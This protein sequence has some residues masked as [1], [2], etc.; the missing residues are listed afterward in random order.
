MIRFISYKNALYLIWFTG[1]LLAQQLPEGKWHHNRE[2]TID[3]VHYKAE[4]NL[5]MAASR[6]SGEAT[7]RFHPR[8]A[9][10]AFSL[11]AFNLN[12]TQVQL[13]QGDSRS[14]LDFFSH[15]RSLAILLDRAYTPQ[16]TLSVTVRYDCQPVD[17]M[18]FQPD[19]ERPGEMFVHTYGEGGLHANWLPI[20]ND[21]N[22]KFSTEM[23]VT[24]PAGYAAIS[25]GALLE[26]RSAVNGALTYH[27]SQ[28]LPHANY[29]I[30]IYA[31]HFEKGELPPAFGKIPLNYWVPE[32]HLAEGAFA[33]RNTTRMVEFFSRQFNH[34]Y[35]WEKYDQVAVPDYAIGAMEHTG[36]TGHRWS[37]LRD[38]TAPDNFGPPLFRQYHDFWTADGTISHELAHHW[39]GN[40]LTC[41]NL[42]YIWLNES[43]ASYLQ[44]LWDEEDLGRETLLLDRQVALD[45][46]LDYVH[47][48]HLIRPLEYH[49]FDMPDDIYN[50]AHTYLKGAI[51]LHMLRG[52]MG[53]EP[54]FR[55]MGYYLKKHQFANVESGDLLDA[56]AE[57]SGQ[58]LDWFFND[59]VYGGGHPV[60][61]VS[62]TYLPDRRQIDLQVK[63]VQA[64]VEGQDLFKLP[65]TVTVATADGEK[66]HHIWLE[67][68]NEAF[69]LP[70]P[71]EPLLVSFDGGGDLVAEVRFE[72]TADELAYQALNDSLPG[73]IQALRQ[74]AA[75][76]PVEAATMETFN[77][78]LNGKYFWGLQAEA[79]VQLG[80]V[81]TPAAAQ[82][83]LRALKSGD[84]RLRKAAA[85]AL[86]ALGAETAAKPLREAIEKDPHT[87]V[88]ATAIVALAQCAPD[89]AGTIIPKQLGRKAWYD[90]ITIACLV[91]LGDLGDAEHLPLIKPYIQPPHN[92]D[93]RQAALTAWK[94][95]A[96]DDP[97]LHRALQAC[98]ERSP[99]RVR[100]FAIA[101]LGE[102]YVVDAR[103]LLETLAQASGDTNLQVLA[104]RA[105]ERIAR[106]ERP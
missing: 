97:E 92:Q 64:Q 28:A 69:F 86:P 46:Y 62:Y 30:S 98:A 55:A 15:S 66:Q 56:I 8:G 6:L 11:D 67:E 22:D 38:A 41:R 31:G 96:P 5:D 78:I 74:L 70:C 37:V 42:S 20:Y 63:Q 76:F 50:E 94:Q 60:F 77:A 34:E 99:Y 105:L 59:W 36:V 12:V 2:Q 17:G 29:L 100:Q 84:A 89:K 72:K 88:V 75:M 21:V 85:M 44:M 32:G 93:V 79:L 54:F 57:A 4:L 102:L 83:L 18:Y 45:Q 58:N 68:Q 48:E 61:E 7:V 91:A 53:D 24:V 65:V 51:V 47:L 26:Q 82:A 87:D 39:F 101:A 106:V 49:R 35:P 9:L 103:L 90:E 40:N 14:A 81:R 10:D 27:W 80:N 23:I 43:F 3:I 16:E 33:F 1:A 25:N 52:I 95:C 19:P 13:L 73:Q 71:G 104:Q